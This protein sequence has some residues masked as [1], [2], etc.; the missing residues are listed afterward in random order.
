[1]DSFQCR[2]CSMKSYIRHVKCVASRTYL[3]CEHC[4]ADHEIR[5]LETPRNAPTE[6]TIIDARVNSIRCADL[7][8]SSAG[9]SVEP[10]RRCG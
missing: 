2:L 1:M 9:S 3:V 10:L 4:A 6:F 8:P 7:S 5:L